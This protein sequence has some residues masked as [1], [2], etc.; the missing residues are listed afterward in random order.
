MAAEAERFT[1]ISEP[2]ALAGPHQ[3]RDDREIFGHVVKDALTL[4]ERTKV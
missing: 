4:A 3:N 1:A 2:A